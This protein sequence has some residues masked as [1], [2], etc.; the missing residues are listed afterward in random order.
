[1]FERKDCR[2]TK[3][4]AGECCAQLHK[5][6]FAVAHQLHTD[7]MEALAVDE[8]PYVRLQ[9]QDL[10]TPKPGSQQ[11]TSWADITSPIR[12][13]SFWTAGWR[14]QR[15]QDL[16]T[17]SP[18]TD[19]PRPSSPIIG[20]SNVEQEADNQ[21]CWNSQWSS[22]E[23]RPS[24]ALQFMQWS[25]AMPS[26][27]RTVRMT[28]QKHASL[29]VSHRHLAMGEDNEG[30]NDSLRPEHQSPSV[31]LCGDTTSGDE[32]DFE[33]FEDSKAPGPSGLQ[34]S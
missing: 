10:K 32:S 31:A 7:G 14:Q 18:A 12:G 33:G 34:Q 21:N 1:M 28:S 13:K 9:A 30:G 20:G 16:P 23:C 3:A 27:H 25:G 19:P 24:L 2:G 17:T 29:P 26:T 6:L 5:D 4:A 8:H 22:S 11:E 15:G